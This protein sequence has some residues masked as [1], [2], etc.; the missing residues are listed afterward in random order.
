MSKEIL[1]G[2]IAS[3]KLGEEHGCLTAE[4]FLE[5]SGWGVSFGGYCLDHWFSDVGEYG[6][7]DGYGAII[8]LMKTLEVNSWEQL[9]GEYVRVE[10]E[11]WGGKVLRI[12]HLMKD[13]WF[14]W[15]KYFAEVHRKHED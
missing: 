2:Q 10:F 4:I 6:S 14:S 12:G 5:G 13:K 9:K 15:D 11:G 8:E 1:N 3:T 7:S